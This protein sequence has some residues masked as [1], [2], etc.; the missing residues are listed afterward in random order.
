MARHEFYP[1]SLGARFFRS[2]AWAV[3]LA[4][5][6]L[7]GVT[8]LLLGSL[9]TGAA[10][11]VLGT[12][13]AIGS[14]EGLYRWCSARRPLVVVEDEALVWRSGLSMRRH[15]LDDL[16]LSPD[17]FDLT[18]LRLQTR[19]GRFL[20]LPRDGVAKAAELERLLRARLE[21]TAASGRATAPTSE[22]SDGSGTVPRR[23][24]Q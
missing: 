4:V 18:V 2:P 19:G 21:P 15:A 17:P 10:D 11:A 24:D 23:D 13:L 12:L 3:F 5:S 1:A 9:K 16:A 6:G 22:A 8:A 14:L 20:R 7:A